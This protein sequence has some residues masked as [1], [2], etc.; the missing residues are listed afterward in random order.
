MHRQRPEYIR[1]TSLTRTLCC[2]ADLSAELLDVLWQGD[3]DRLLFAAVPLQ[4]KDRCIVARY[5]DARDTLLLKRHIWGGIGRSLRMAWREPWGRRCARLGLYLSDRGVPTPRPRACLE[6]RVGPLGYRS[7][8]FTDFIEGT[9][10]YR[11]IRQGQASADVLEHIAEQV[12]D[13]WRRLVELGVSHGDMKPENFIVGKN[14]RVWL[15]DLERMRI[16]GRLECRR[17]EQ[18][19]DVETF[20]HIRGWHQQPEARE[21]FRRAFTQT[22]AGRRLGVGRDERSTSSTSARAEVDATLFVLFICDDTQIDS[23]NAQQAID[24]VRDIAD[25]VVI[26]TSFAVGDRLDDASRIELSGRDDVNCD[27]LLVV[28]QNE[29]VTPVLAKRIQEAI[30]RAT[31]EDAYRIAIERQFFGRSLSLEGGAGMSPV[32][33][34]RPN[35]C[36]FSVANG[37]LTIAADPDRTG[38]LEGTI[39]QSVASS[40]SELVKILDH[41]TTRSAGQ[42]LN[43]GQRPRWIVA[44]IAA[45]TNFVKRCLGPDGLRSGLIGIHLA[46]LQAIFEWVEEVKLWQMSGQFQ[47]QRSATDAPDDELEMPL[48]DVRRM[49]LPASELPA[50]KAA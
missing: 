36:S 3:V 44:A 49:P 29:C 40:V 43:D 39:Q 12:A 27:W 15:L 2:D 22:A 45:A 33:L 32:R 8:L 41:Q 25:Q 38:Q 7:Y 18:A 26:G 34:F 42:R 31:R 19:A 37:Q 28:H 1:R 13:I 35:R 11:F 10:L 16:G 30:S 4:V 17:R 6:H 21:I 48:P 5:A 9:S 24:S 23:A 50:A 14:L 20:L 47:S 46:V